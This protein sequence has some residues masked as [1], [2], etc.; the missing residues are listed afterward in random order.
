MSSR[1][2]EL[3]RNPPDR[4]D[5]DTPPISNR[6][7]AMYVVALVIALVL[8]YLFLSKLVDISQ[9][10]DCALAHRRNCGASTNP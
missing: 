6:R 3:S 10:E 1:D 9:E 5:G 2:D 8:G 4:G 7:L